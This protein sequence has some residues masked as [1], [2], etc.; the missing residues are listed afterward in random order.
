MAAGRG[1]DHA[2]TNVMLENEHLEE[3]LHVTARRGSEEK[4]PH[5]YGTT[6]IDLQ[7][8][9]THTHTRTRFSLGL[10]LHLSRAPI[11]PGQ[12]HRHE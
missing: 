5:C 8:P 11:S 1:R 9:L 3:V 12:P 7:V 6:A 2:G 4:V 10:A